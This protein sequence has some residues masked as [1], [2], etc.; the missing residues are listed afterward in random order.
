MPIKDTTMLNTLFQAE[1]GTSIQLSDIFDWLDGRGELDKWAEDME[2]LPLDEIETEALLDEAMG[3]SGWKERFSEM[4][5]EQDIS[6]LD[7]FDQ[8][9]INECYKVEEQS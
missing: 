1:F 9:T 2:L 5:E 6:P 3:R 4:A 7:L 8:A